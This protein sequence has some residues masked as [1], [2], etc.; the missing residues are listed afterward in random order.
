MDGGPWAPRHPHLTYLERARP[1]DSTA[2]LPVGDLLAAPSSPLGT[3]EAF[4]A[5]GDP[6][7]K[8]VIDE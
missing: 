2:F 6:W 8:G 7:E 4:L 5:L 1:K 3:R